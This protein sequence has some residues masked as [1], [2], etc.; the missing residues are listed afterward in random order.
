MSWLSL[1][2][3]LTPELIEKY[4]GEWNMQYLSLNPSLTPEIIE[5]NWGYWDR[6]RLSRNPVIF[7]GGSEFLFMNW[8]QS[9]WEVKE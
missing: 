4:W 5:R 6:N 3:A 9:P 1:N 2:L 7:K 8:N